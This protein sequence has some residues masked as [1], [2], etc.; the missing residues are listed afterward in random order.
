MRGWHLL[1]P[2]VMLLAA[3]TAGGSRTDPRPTSAGGATSSQ[4]ANLSAAPSLPSEALP[5]A[6]HPTPGVTVA[7]DNLPLAAGDGVSIGLHPTE[8]PIT[9]R[10]TASMPLTVCPDGNSDV[11][12]GLSWPLRQFTEC[13]LVRQNEWVQMP[14]S[15]TN[16]FHIGFR[17][18]AAR[19]GTIRSLMISYQRVDAFFDV[20]TNSA[21]MTAM[22][23]TFTP[24]GN[25]AAATIYYNNNQTGP[26]NAVALTQAGRA[27][28][29][30]GA[31][32]FLTEATTCFRGLSAGQPATVRVLHAPDARA[33][34]LGLAWP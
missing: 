22:T 17:I 6:A 32:T 10:A 31:C 3:C 1:F 27:R 14:S 19:S 21:S 2:G 25:S 12:T 9:F 29:A 30:T 8:A 16:T 13:F 20:I 23:T 28:A 5:T 26:P 24:A 15:H 34:A 4:A 18:G 33:V 7:L 11:E